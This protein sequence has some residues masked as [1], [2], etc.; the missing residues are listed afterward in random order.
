VEGA[1]RYARLRNAA[2]GIEPWNAQLTPYMIEP[3]NM[4][5][6][7]RYQGVH[8][9]GPART[10]KTGG[11]LAWVA[12]VVKGDP[13]DMM[14][15]HMTQ[16][17][18]AKFSKKELRRLLL[19]SP[20][21]A[22]EMPSSK[23]DD[24]IF[25]KLFRNGMVL[26][27]G[28]PSDTQLRAETLRYMALTD[29]DGIHRNGGNEGSVFKRA[30]KRLQTSGSRAALYCES[31]PGFDVIDPR[32]QAQSPHEAPPTDGILALY[33]QGT[34]CRRY[35]LCPI[36]NERFIEPLSYESAFSYRHQDDLLGH[37]VADLV[38]GWG[39]LCTASGCTI[40]PEF[41]RQVKA[42]GVWVPDGCEV[43]AAGEV[44]GTPRDVPFASYWLSGVSAAYQRWDSLLLGYLQA[45]RRYE[46]TGDEDDLRAAYNVDLG[47]P[48][49]PHFRQALRDPSG[50]ATRTEA[51]ERGLVP[52]PVRLLVARVDVQCGRTARFV[53]QVDGLGPG[54]ES[55]VIDRY[56]V[57]WSE[58]VSREEGP[59][60]VKPETYSE[61]WDLLFTQVISRR[62]PLASDDGLVMGVHLVVIDSA[63]SG[64]DAQQTSVTDQ[65]YSFWRRAKARGLAHQV[66]LYKGSSSSSAPR[67][68]RRYP[69]NRE[70]SDRRARALGDVPVLFGNGN[71]LKDEI[72]NAMDRDTDGPGKMHWPGWLPREF[73]DELTAENRTPGGWRKISARNETLDLYVMLYAAWYYLRLDRVNWELPPV[74]AGVQSEEHP[75]ISRV[76]HGD[77]SHDPEPLPLAPSR[78]RKVRMR[79]H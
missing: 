59:Q 5:G 63:G 33:N 40:P 32:W 2:G 73:F 51:L 46:Q 52:A 49:R 9:V 72:A 64:D 45:R 4:L 48:Y 68:E 62:Y 55:W 65:A 47:V 34:R 39:L 26:S 16:D 36:C 43:N 56:S 44:T 1:T 79:A 41:E 61:D 31:S 57:K 25:S 14:I 11:L 76:E 12:H 74:W 60:R 50:L 27:I 78:G 30:L 19:D 17:K 71:L 18:A 35:L 10:G 3:L 28:W 8:F 20:D 23:H 21:L 77:G 7:R 42:S 37:T 15:L 66:L 38:P 53:V 24:N 69:D 6:S 58:R 70:R 54:R 22:A 67:V 13:G 29:Y 75:A